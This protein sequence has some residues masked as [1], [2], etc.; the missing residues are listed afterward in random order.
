ML[1]ID[2][3]SSPKDNEKCEKIVGWKKKFD[4]F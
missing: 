4:Y 1:L 3:F 2:A